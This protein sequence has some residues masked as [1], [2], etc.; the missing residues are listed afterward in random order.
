LDGNVESGDDNGYIGDGNGS[1]GGDGGGGAV[2]T[3]MQHVSVFPPGLGQEGV[4][5]AFRACDHR[6]LSLFL[7]VLKPV[8]ELG[9]YYSKERLVRDAMSTADAAFRMCYRP[10]ELVGSDTIVRHHPP[11]ASTYTWPFS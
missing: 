1:I 6:E 2:S 9:K 4:A 3:S 11:R 8:L 5:S 10:K 7:N